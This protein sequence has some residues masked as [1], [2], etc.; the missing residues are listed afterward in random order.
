MKK[1]KN[2]L[3]RKLVLES[4]LNIISSISVQLKNPIALINHNNEI[5]I[6][7]HID[8]DIDEIIKN[9]NLQPDG[10][11]KTENCLV[12]LIKQDNLFIGA[13]F[14]SKINENSEKYLEMAIDM[15][16]EIKSRCYEL[17]DTTHQWINTQDELSLLYRYTQKF[18]LENNEQEIINNLLKEITNKINP[19]QVHILLYNEET[20][21]LTVVDE[22]SKK[23]LIGNYVNDNTLIYNL[24]N[25]RAHEIILLNHDNKFELGLDVS[26]SKMLAVS[27]FTKDKPI[28]I[29]C[30]FDKE[31][32]NEEFYASDLSFV[33]TLAV[34]VSVAIRNIHLI[35]ELEKNYKFESE[36]WREVSFRASH[37]MGNVLYGLRGDVT[38]LKEIFKEKP[39]DEKEMEDAIK[40]V[41]EGLNEANSIVREFK[42]YYSQDKLNLELKNINEI[43]LS[44]V[45]RM[46]KT[47]PQHI[48][49]ETQ[50]AENLPVVNIDINQFKDLIKQMILNSCNF[51]KENGVIIFISRNS[52]DE[53]KG[54]ANINKDSITFIVEDTGKGVEQK[55]KRKIFY[56]FF[57]TSA[58]GSG[59]G[60]AIIHKYIEQL[61]GKIVE[62]GVPEKG[63]KFLMVLP[64]S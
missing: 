34:P 5:I 38:I 1:K 8:I 30:A 4:V 57:S 20:A 2:K 36:A 48:T 58:K 40:G 11:I 41:T 52:T 26:A 60:L 46:Q 13:L 49:I 16:K 25:S 32:D 39:L 47:L 3:I 14:I 9:A 44:E 59:L 42:E 37:K 27:L 23:S 33:I 56:P 21:K 6:G 28:G 17:V 61:G 18:G 35:Q 10:I 22:C 64:V 31:D 55:N 15:I 12:H 29:I 63:A 51:I 50:L 45:S 54:Y 53:D 19:K 7:T 43:I 24:Y 62:I